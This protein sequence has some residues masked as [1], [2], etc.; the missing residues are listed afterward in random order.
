M[1]LIS[2]LSYFR[3]ASK[4]NLV[5]IFFLLFVSTNLTHAQ[6][7]V[8]KHSFYLPL[9]KFPESSIDKIRTYNEIEAVYAVLEQ[10]TL[11][12]PNLHTEYES[13]PLYKHYTKYEKHALRKNGESVPFEDMSIYD[14]GETNNHTLNLYLGRSGQA[15]KIDNNQKE[16][17]IDIS[18]G[19]FSYEKTDCKNK[20]GVNRA[21]FETPYTA[22]KLAVL[23]RHK[24]TKEVF[25]AE[26]IDIHG[27]IDTLAAECT[28]SLDKKHLRKVYV[29]KRSEIYDAVANSLAHEQEL[30]VRKVIQENILFGIEKVHFKV[31]Y[32]KSKKYDYSELEKAFQLAETSY[33]RYKNDGINAASLNEIEKAVKVWELFLK[34]SDLGDKKAKVNL[35]VT[36]ALHNN[37][38]MAY[39][40][41]LDYEKSLYHERKAAQIKNMMQVSFEPQFLNLQRTFHN[42]SG[43]GQIETNKLA[44]LYKESLNESPVIIKK[45]SADNFP[46]LANKAKD[47]LGKLQTL[48][49]P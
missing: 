22:G 15:M 3:H 46:T 19:R 30:L 27:S 10:I 11:D 31:A 7:K 17:K 45:Q 6:S 32:A 43:W 2:P 25:H 49:G 48:P 8:K 14:T 4:F 34:E 40:V 26:I 36:R 29:K 28:Q 21:M 41:L 39:A 38:R 12:K 35:K 13:F 16:H 47:F 1:Q 42:N 18:N 33:E 20:G 5:I 24:K 44:S 23:I 9:L 37:L